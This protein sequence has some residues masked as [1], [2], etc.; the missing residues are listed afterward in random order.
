MKTKTMFIKLV[1]TAYAPEGEEPEQLRSGELLYCRDIEI[2]EKEM[3]NLIIKV[4]RL[5]EKELG[6]N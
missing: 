4:K 3:G 1:A 2:P 5:L 6:L